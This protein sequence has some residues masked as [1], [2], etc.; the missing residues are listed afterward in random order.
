MK[1]IHTYAHA[2]YLS[3]YAYIEMEYKPRYVKLFI[4]SD[5][6]EKL[7]DLTTQYYWG[8]NTVPFTAAQI[9]DLLKSKYGK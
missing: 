3:V 2:F 1:H 8:G 5:I 7:V 4:D 6:S 9:V